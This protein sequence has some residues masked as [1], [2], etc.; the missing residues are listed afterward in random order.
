VALAEGTKPAPPKARQIAAVVAGNALEFYDFVTYSFFA[1]Q[2]GR[3]LFP[4]NAGQT[5]ILS[6]ATF[7]VGFVTRPL[8]GFVIGRFA[9]RRGRKPAMIV[10]FSLMGIGLIGLALT[11]SYAAAGM[12]A[13]ALAILF[14]LLQGFAL[15]GEVGPNIAFLI[16]TAAPHR[17][18]FIVSLH[19]ASADLGVLVAGTIGLALSS[20][21]TPA[22]L[23]AYGWRIAFLVGATIVPFGLALRRTLAETLPAAEAE[24]MPDTRDRTFLIAAAAGLMLLGAATIAN[25]TLDYLTTYAQTSLHMAVNVAFGSTVLL[26]L[27]GVAGDLG[28]GWLVDRI[29]RK[30]LIRPCWALLMLFAVPAFLVLSQYRTAG[31]L[32]GVTIFLTTLHI[33]GSTPALLLFAEALP[34][35]TR[36]GGL[37]IVYALSIALFGGTAQVIDK[38]L[39]DWTGSALAP[40]WY[41]SAAIACGLIGTF[42]IREA[43]RADPV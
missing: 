32:Y 1:A 27:V 12:A 8:G 38:A 37:G 40:G 7:G 20:F 13:P 25:Y 29:G 22:Q 30:R 39:T 2:I 15:G 35:R 36:A 43:R 3:S 23:D 42:F 33:F 14:R 17:R 4:G 6:L 34:A 21:L 9:D 16:E 41:M 18:G 31:A 11:P 19:A 5:L 10:S 28:S 26:G 24:A